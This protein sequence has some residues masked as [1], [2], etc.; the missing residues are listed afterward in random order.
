M[1]AVAPKRHRLRTV[2]V[3]Y[4]NSGGVDRPAVVLV[5]VKNEVTLSKDPIEKIYSV[6]LHG[7]CAS[8]QVQ[9]FR[10]RSSMFP[11][12]TTPS[13]F[14]RWV[15][16]WMRR[17]LRFPVAQDTTVR[18]NTLAKNHAAEFEELLLCS[19]YSINFLEKLGRMKIVNM[20]LDRR[21]ADSVRGDRQG[22]RARFV[23]FSLGQGRQFC[24][25]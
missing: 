13:L 22:E 23:L 17:G 2:F 25:V 8:Y 21:K 5:P 19:L 16:V 9:R 11:N 6:E 10:M 20:I 24:H 4:C 18:Y 14:H 1:L 3:L 7:A 12:H 15:C